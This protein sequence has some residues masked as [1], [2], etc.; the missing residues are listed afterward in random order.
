MPHPLTTLGAGIKA[1]PLLA[2]FGAKVILT[3]GLLYILWKRDR[4]SPAA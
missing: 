3:A 2:L 4:S 1:H